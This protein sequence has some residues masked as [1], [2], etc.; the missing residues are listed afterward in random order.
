[1]SV[2]SATEQRGLHQRLA[3]DLLSVYTEK[4]SLAVEVVVRRQILIG[5]INH[6]IDLIEQRGELEMLGRNSDF[7]A[8]MRGAPGQLKMET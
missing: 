5:D 6:Q 1:M 2:E 4:M 3:N 8:E 7:R